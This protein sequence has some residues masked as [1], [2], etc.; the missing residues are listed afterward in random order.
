MVLFHLVQV[1]DKCHLNRSFGA[2][3]HQLNVP[4]KAVVLV[5]NVQLR[6]RKEGVEGRGRN[7]QPNIDRWEKRTQL[8]IDSAFK[9]FKFLGSGIALR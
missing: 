1:T 8:L 3:A 6:R 5:E 7:I 9:K 4:F 2:G